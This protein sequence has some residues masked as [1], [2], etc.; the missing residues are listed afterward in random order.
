MR[1]FGVILPLLLALLAQ[2]AA[3]QDHPKFR[4][5]GDRLIYDTENVPE[6]V[7]DS[8]ESEDVDVILTLLRANGGIRVLELNSTGGSLWA[9]RKI[10]DIVIDFEL[11]THVNGEC[12]SNCTRLLLAGVNRTMSRGSRIGFHQSWWSPES[13]EGYFAR[14]AESEGWDT[15][16]D[17]ASW[18]YADTQAEVHELLT[19]MVRRGVDG[20]F[21]IETLKTPS[22]DIWH[23]YRARLRAA[24]VLTE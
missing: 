12:S 3:A 11:D 23:P 16:W 9:S 20:A 14:E 22:G 21:A 5:D 24:N 6:G 1:L 15:P 18:I 19:Y 10:S 4:V 2:G 13:I 17:F 7:S 8:I